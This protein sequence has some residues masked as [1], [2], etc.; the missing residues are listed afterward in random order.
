MPNGACECGVAGAMSGSA[1]VRGAA[2][3]ARWTWP[4]SF[5]YSGSSLPSSAAREPSAL[6][7]LR[8]SSFFAV[9]ITISILLPASQ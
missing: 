2:T 6:S 8:R 4:H 1:E 9:M 5:L 7:E 3:K